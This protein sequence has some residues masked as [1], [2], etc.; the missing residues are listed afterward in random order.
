MQNRRQILGYSL[1]PNAP[2]LRC[3]ALMKLHSQP[4]PV[5][6]VNNEKGNSIFA[7]VETKEFSLS[8]CTKFIRRLA[9]GWLEGQ[10]RVYSLCLAALK[11]DCERSGGDWAS[12]LINWKGH[13]YAVY[14]T[15]LFKVDV[16]LLPIQWF[17]CCHV[18]AVPLI[19]MCC[20]DELQSLRRLFRSII[21]GDIYLY[22][23]LGV[24]TWHS[25]YRTRRWL[26]SWATGGH[27]MSTVIYRRYKKSDWS[28]PKEGQGGK[29]FGFSRKINI[30][31]SFLS[32]KCF[33][34]KNF[35]GFLL[36]EIN[37]I[38]FIHCFTLYFQNRFLY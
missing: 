7:R 13:G 22:I 16:Y 32:D 31:F 9:F 5:P 10:R 25:I 1:S 14:F 11:W 18:W 19:V 8:L 29:A 15:F 36:R 30:N 28:A 3:Q 38:F 37:I 35:F 20:A 2:E 12:V 17:G 26:S 21:K 33:E 34:K 27:Q 23:V 24:T 6:A 4:V